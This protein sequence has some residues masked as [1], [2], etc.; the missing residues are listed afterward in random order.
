M[1]REY[2][3]Q[4][5]AGPSRDCGAVYWHPLKDGLG[6]WRDRYSA[7]CLTHHYASEPVALDQIGTAWQALDEHRGNA[8]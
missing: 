7:I 6:K 1:N 3:S 5:T 4:N 8:S 2:T